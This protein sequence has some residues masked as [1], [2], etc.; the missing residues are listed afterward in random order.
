MHVD[1]KA[2]PEELFRLSSGSTETEQ[3]K[4]STDIELTAW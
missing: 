2:L 1:S 4:I 3:G